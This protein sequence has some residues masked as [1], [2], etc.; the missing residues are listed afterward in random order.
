VPRSE[1]IVRTPHA[2]HHL[3]QLG[4][5]FATAVAVKT[6]ANQA[7]IDFTF[8]TCR[9][10]ATDDQLTLHADGLDD[11]CLARIEYLV[12]EHLERLGARESLTTDWQPVTDS[13]PAQ[14]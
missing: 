1:A 10:D 4:E 8:G 9:L 5:H 13:D 14:A 2:L 11:I 12:G 7:L 3:T 6:T